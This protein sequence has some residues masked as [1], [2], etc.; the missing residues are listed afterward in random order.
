MFNRSLLLSNGAQ[1]VTRP[2]DMREVDL[3][4][5]FFF[6]V[7][8]ARRRPRRTGRYLGAAAEMFPHQFR[9]EIL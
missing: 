2:R 6:A 8:G 9:F 3:G 4:L 1:H 7:N 5:D